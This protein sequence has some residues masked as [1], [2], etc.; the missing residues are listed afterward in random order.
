ML[1]SEN[2]QITAAAG[3][4][5]KEGVGRRGSAAANRSRLLTAPRGRQFPVLG[6]AG[7]TA[8]LED[9]VACVPFDGCADYAEESA[10]IRYLMFRQLV[11]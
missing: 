7:I 9:D 10:Y 6:A 5:E 4:R 3:M 8:H 1:P 11:E 2:G